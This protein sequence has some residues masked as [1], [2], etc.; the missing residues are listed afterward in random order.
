MPLSRARRAREPLL[1]HE[2]GVGRTALLLS[3]LALVALAVIAVRLYRTASNVAPAAETSQTPTAAAP[4]PRSGDQ[5]AES[6]VATD[7][8]FRQESGRILP[9]IP[10][11]P[12]YPGAKLVGSAEQA[13]SGEPAEGYRIK[14]TTT[15]SVAA[16]M[17]WYAKALPAAGWK[18]QT[19]EDAGSPV[20]QLARIQKDYMDGYVSAEATKD[21]TEIIVSLQDTRRATRRGQR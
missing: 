14:W 10:E 11:V 20:E 7:P 15:D 19:P 17:Q 13:R 16:V 9:E 21:V 18:H 12:A 1:H 3:I 4:S 8:S 5:P 2:N 6:K